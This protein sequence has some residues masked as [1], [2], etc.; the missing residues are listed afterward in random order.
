VGGGLSSFNGLGHNSAGFSAVQNWTNQGGTFFAGTAWNGYWTAYLYYAGG[1]NSATAPNRRSSSQNGAPL[2]TLAA[3]NNVTVSG[4][5]GSWT[6]NVQ[7]T[8]YAGSNV[9][10]TS[11]G[12][13]YGRGHNA[14]TGTN[15]TAG[16]TIIKYSDSIALPTSGTFTSA[17]TGG[18]RYVTCASSTT[19]RWG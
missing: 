18:F 8:A 15:G 12:G 16:V 6:T 14:R 13:T 7:S 1:G 4:G 3:F 9:E 10:G 2:T 19:L 5:G 17:T 11:G